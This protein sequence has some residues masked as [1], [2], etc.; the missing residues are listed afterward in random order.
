MD[1]GIVNHLLCWPQL[2]NVRVYLA[3]EQYICLLLNVTT[4]FNHFAIIWIWAFHDHSPIL[5][6]HI[7][8]SPPFLLLALADSLLLFLSLEAFLLEKLLLAHE[9]CLH[10]F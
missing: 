3:V 2:I 10:L 8:S 1:M 4:N 6:G 5:R 9:F 7:A